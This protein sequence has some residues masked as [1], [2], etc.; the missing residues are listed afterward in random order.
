MIAGYHIIFGAYGH[1]LPNDPAGSWSEFV[2]SW[3]LFRYGRATKKLALTGKVDRSSFD[4]ERAAAKQLLRRKP[5]EFTGLQARAVGQGFASYVER[6]GL[7]IWACAIMPDHVHLVVGPPGMKVEQLVIQLKGSATQRLLEEG[8]HPFQHQRDKHGRPHK[9][10]ARGE[11]KV[12]LDPD[13]VESAIKYVE[14]NPINEGL[15]AQ[16]WR[17]VTRPPRDALRG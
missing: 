2:G 15:P 6:S 10:F 16:R 8:I 9:C 14:D 4:A 3:E 12:Y 13:D 5:V 7:L 17:F 11:W 1:W